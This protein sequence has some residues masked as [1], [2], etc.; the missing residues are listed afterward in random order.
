MIKLTAADGH[1]FAAYRADPNGKP[2]GGIVV[3]QGIFGLNRT[4]QIGSPTA[5]PRRATRHRSGACSTAS[6]SDSTSP[7]NTARR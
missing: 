4:N 5:M 3:I 7:S 2:S 6:S 1:T